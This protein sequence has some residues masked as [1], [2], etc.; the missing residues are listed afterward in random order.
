MV[1][2]IVDDDGPRGRALTRLKKS[3]AEFG[4]G[5][6]NRAARARA[7]ERELEGVDKI[8]GIQ[9]G[10]EITAR[11]KGRVF[12][13]LAR[14]QEHEVSDD[15]CTA[16]VDK[17]RSSDDAVVAIVRATVETLSVEAEA[18]VV[19]V[20][21]TDCVEVDAPKATVISVCLRQ[22]QLR[23]YQV[24]GLRAHFVSNPAP[25]WAGNIVGG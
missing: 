8:T 22:Y 19:D 3:S 24:S 9:R 4:V 5:T 11:E 2:P 21:T 15:E 10:R 17:D 20:S 6:E 12:G 18:A 7:R 1:C 14:R 23:F 16:I 13:R 25:P